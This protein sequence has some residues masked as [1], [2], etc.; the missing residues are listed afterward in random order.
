MPGPPERGSQA[1]MTETTA[2]QHTFLGRLLDTIERVG[3][4]VPHPAIIFII[5][6]AGVIVLSQILYIVGASVTYEVVAPPPVVGEQGY[7]PGSAVEVPFVPPAFDYH[8]EELHV[9]HETT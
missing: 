6:I 4:K 8:E 3:N 7:P 9:E 1:P 2:P 5:L